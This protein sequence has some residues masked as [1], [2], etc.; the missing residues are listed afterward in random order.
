MIEGLKAGLALIGVVA[1]SLLTIAML[2]TF[3]RPPIDST[4]IGYDGVGMVDHVNPRLE[5]EVQA[6]NEPP[7]SLGAVPPG[8]RPAGEAYENVQVLADLS[9]DQFNH[10][11]VGITNWVSPEEGCAYCHNLENLASDE[12]YTKV[13]SRRMIQMTMTI[14]SEYSDHVGQTGV[15]CYTCHRGNNVPEYLWVEEDGPKAM[16]G[17]SASRQDQNVPTRIAGYSTMPYTALETL[18]TEPGANIRVATQ[19]A[20][21]FVREAGA[22]PP[23]DI[24]DTEVTY[25]LMMNMSQG[26]G[27]NCTYCHNS[28]NWSSWEQSTPM[29]VTAWHGIQMAQDINANYLIPLQPVLPENR[30]GPAGDAPKANCETCH[31]GLALP[32]NGAP[33]LEDHPELGESYK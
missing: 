15:N 20:L 1:V 19:S 25:S 17:V 22:A 32:M 31:Q 27:V 12:L 16:A 8:G 28:R 23:P 21:P 3:E 7:F 4:Q 33:M 14:N 13:V 26:L 30:L 2:I 11:M 29:R 18:L 5:E 9:E 6:R 24:K 10:L